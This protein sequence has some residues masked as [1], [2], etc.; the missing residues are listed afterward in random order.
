MNL[1][2]MIDIRNFLRTHGQRQQTGGIAFYPKRH[3]SFFF[4]ESQRDRS[5]RELLTQTHA[6]NVRIYQRRE[7]LLL[8]LSFLFLD[9]PSQSSKTIS[10]VSASSTTKAQ[11]SSK[12]RHHDARAVHRYRP[13]HRDGDHIHS[14]SR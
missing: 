11:T 5:A 3:K 13:R 1:N 2:D 6:R 4:S 10:N 7:Y 14:N 9:L 12:A 8:F